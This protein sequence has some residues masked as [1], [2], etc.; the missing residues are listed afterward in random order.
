MKDNINI[1]TLL[2][3]KFMQILE[4][5]LQEERKIYLEEHTDPGA[6]L[7]SRFET[8]LWSDKRYKCA[9]ELG[10]RG[11]GQLLPNKRRSLKKP[12]EINHALLIS[13]EFTCK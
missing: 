8:P 6:W 11:K 13:G 7:R 10:W 3:Q 1:L 5:M 12:Q 4:K 2:P 9:L